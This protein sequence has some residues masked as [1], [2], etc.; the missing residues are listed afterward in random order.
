MTW[1]P[2]ISFALAGVAV[3]PPALEAA[4]QV[5]F[6]RD[7][8]PV[9]ASQCATCHM[10]TEDPGGMK[11]YPSAAYRSIVN[12]PSKGSSLLRVRPGDPQSS[13]LLHKL[14]GTH[15]DVGGVGVRMP[16]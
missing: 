1:R 3:L 16:F 4:D 2:F 15:L 14:E 5:S 9:L 7:I 13:Y 8:A 10:S 6:A 12:A 11:L